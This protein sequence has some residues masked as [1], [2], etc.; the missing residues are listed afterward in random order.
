MALRRSPFPNGLVAG[1]HAAGWVLIFPCFWFLDQL[2]AVCVST[3]LERN[4]RLEKECYLHPL[5]VVFGSLVFFVLFLIAAP[6]AFLGFLLWA[7]LQAV[8]RP[9]SYHEEVPSI[10]VEDRNQ[11]WKEA[12]KV[13][14]GFVTANV[15]LLPNGLARFNNLGHT[16]RRATAIGRYIVQG[17]TRPHIRIFVDSPSSCGSTLSPSS[18]LMPQAA[19]C[20][21]G[22]TESQPQGCGDPSPEPDATL[23]QSNSNRDVAVSVPLDDAKE[24]HPLPSA[25]SNQNSNQQ[26]DRSRRK[27]PRAFEALGWDTD[28]VLEVSTLFPASVDFVC[29]E[30]V[31]DKRAAQK[32]KQALGPLFGHVLYDV[33]VY[34][35][36]PVGGCSSFKFFNSGLFVASRYPLVEAE[37]RCFPN[38]RG[39]DALAAKGLLCV[40]VLIGLQ[41]EIER[42]LVGYFNCTHLHAPEGDGTIRHEQLDMLMKWISEF[43]LA[44]KEDNELVLF[45][46]LCGDLNFDNCSPDDALEQGHDLFD[47]YRDFCRDGPGKEKPWV[48]GTL[49][50]QPSLYDDDTKTPENLQRVLEIEELR[51]QYLSP[52]VAKPG[53]P[54][55]YPESGQTW[56]G[57]RLDYILYRESTIAKNCQTEVDEFTYVT[58]LAGLTDHIPVGLRLNVTFSSEETGETPQN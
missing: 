34:A 28:V 48:I 40:K 9:F 13:T 31:F 3:S 6:I 35:C 38:G 5:K 47:V 33:G 30:E 1:L 16:Q 49:L 26:G 43:Q 57:R 22:A 27:L 21:Y 52:P 11:G 25:N 51:K 42:K 36:Q 55:V 15:C 58:Q 41:D 20:S 39:E 2:I 19:S 37:Y 24:P 12:G 54:I 18:S 50:E 23:S 44:N 8:R 56:V 45:D 32:L 7:P 14:F 53:I 29:L 4:R 46:V 10:P 17:A